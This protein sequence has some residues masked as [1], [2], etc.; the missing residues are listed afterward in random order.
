MLIP[1]SMRVPEWLTWLV[2]ALPF[3]FTA[4]VW[5]L[6]PET[7]PVHWGVSGKPDDFAAKGARLFWVLLLLPLANVIVYGMFWLIPRI[8]PKRRLD[9]R[10][11][12]LPHLRFMLAFVFM[13]LHGAILVSMVQGGSLSRL[14]P[15]SVVLIFLGMGNY[16]GAVPHNYFIGLR[17]PWTLE[18]AEVWRRTHR[19]AGRIWVGVSLGALLLLFVLPIDVFFYVLMSA[20]ALLVGVPVVYSFMLF[21]RLH[22]AGTS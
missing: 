6:L 7:V 4:A 13:L 1:P 14:L 12:P 22:P 18:S 2:L 8:D 10:S 9:A 5:P 3:V 21:R 17:T 16:L 19:L 15:M 20:T 11:K